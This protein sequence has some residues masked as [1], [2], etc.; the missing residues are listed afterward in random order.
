MC[1]IKYRYSDILLKK[2]YTSFILLIKLFEKSEKSV[3]IELNLHATEL[4][5]HT[6]VL[7]NK[8]ELFGT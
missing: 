1:S 4:I 6:P 2:T 5:F 3:L 8:I 7:A